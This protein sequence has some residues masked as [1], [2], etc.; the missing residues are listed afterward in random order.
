M[1]SPLRPLTILSPLAPYPPLSGGT[2]H[3]LRV[4]QQLAQRY[5]VSFVALAPAP[6]QV[7]WG[8]LAA[9][10]ASVRAF[11]RTQRSKWG[12][13][14]PAARQ[15]HS[16]ELLAYL[17][18][19]WAAQPPAIVQLEY[20]SMAQYARPARAAG[21]LVACTAIELAFRT[22]VRRARQERD[23]RLKARRWLGALSLWRYELATLPQC[24]LVITL[25]EPDALALR[26]WLPRLTVE[27]I[28]SGIDLA[29]WP[30][31]RTP[32]AGA[33]VLFVGNYLHPPNVDGALWLAREVWPLVR[34]AHPGARLTL[35]GRDPPAAIQ[36]LAAPD[37]HIPGA[38]ADMRPL[39]AQA[40]L[41]AA[42]IF[43][44]SGVRIKLIEALACG[45]PVVT[46]ALAAEGIDLRHAQS[47]LFAEQPAGFADAI[48]RLLA[49]PV[50]RERLGAAGRT[51]IERD[52]DAALVGARLEALYERRLALRGA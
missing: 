34:L 20:T 8:P 13:N 19:A 44:G 36:A 24:D 4:T 49:D 17:R 5:Q 32:R 3:M 46:T 40:T 6:E 42:P 39:Y 12:F 1:H 11:R 37:I 21:A 27:Y 15:E 2:A 33:Q 25:S 38:V 29:E 31:C 48:V 30:V 23:A 26:R 14:P 10:C 45:L 22:Q 7:E 9:Q 47:V 43:W 28:P 16:A 41:V 50:L 18:R 35:A 52:Y 51:L